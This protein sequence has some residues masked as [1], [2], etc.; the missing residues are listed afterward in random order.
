VPTPDNLVY[1][2]AEI[3]SIGNAALGGSDWFD[4]T[5]VEP[6]KAA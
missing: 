3:A 4:E 1:G 6:L 2:Y 5:L